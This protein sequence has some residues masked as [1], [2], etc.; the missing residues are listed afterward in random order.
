MVTGFKLSIDAV[1]NSF[2]A[3]VALCGKQVLLSCSD[4]GIKFYSCCRNV[5]REREVHLDA[6]D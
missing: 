5:V 2:F 3:G 4:L 1:I 6:D